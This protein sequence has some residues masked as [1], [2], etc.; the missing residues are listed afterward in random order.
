MPTTS[1]LSNMLFVVHFEP[2]LVLD[3]LDMA[4]WVETFR[5]EFPVYQQTAPS[6]RIELNQTDNFLVLN[7]TPEMPRMFLQSSSVT[8]TLQL[9][10]DRFGY[11]WARDKPLGEPADYPGYPRMREDWG[12]V[13]AR[14][15]DWHEKR[16]GGRPVTRLLELA[17]HNAVPIQ[18]GNR[19]RKLSELIRFVHDGYRPMNSFAMNWSELLT[20]EMTGSRV[21]AQAGLGVSPTGEPVFGFTFA[22]LAPFSEPADSVAA[23]ETMDRLHDRIIDMRDNSIISDEPTKK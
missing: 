11:G 1:M 7:H 3:V 12:R 21:N 17:Y 23:V 8:R 15:Y 20:R 19:R 9:Q 22:G 18:A 16:L 13:L 10:S 4:D 14:F 6:A 5:A 2:A